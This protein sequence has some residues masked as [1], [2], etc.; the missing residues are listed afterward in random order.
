M[1][2]ALSKHVEDEALLPEI[3]ERSIDASSIEPSVTMLGQTL[4]QSYTPSE[5]VS[6]Q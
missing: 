5:A 1:R 4:T 3:L 6:A 2:F